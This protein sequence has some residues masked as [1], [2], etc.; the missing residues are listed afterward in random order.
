MLGPFLE[1]ALYLA[2]VAEE[3]SFLRA[4]SRLHISPS[5]ITRKI[6]QAERIVG[7]RLFERSTRRVTLTAAGQDLL[8]EVEQSLRHAERAIHLARYRARIERGPFRCGYC[9]LVHGKIVPRLHQLDMEFEGTDGAASMGNPVGM[10]LETAATPQ[11]VE[12]VLRGEL[13][14]GIGVAPLDEHGLWVEPLGREAFCV[15]MPKNHELARPSAVQVRDFNQ[16]LMFW[17]PREM[18]PA[19]YDATVE[20]TKS[21]GAEINFHPVYCASQAINIVAHGFGLALLPASAARCT[22]LGAVFRPLAD[23]FLEVESV[24]FARRERWR[25][26][27]KEQIAVLLDRL[28]VNV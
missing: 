4:A 7:V 13:D 22:H 2:A 9:P 28:R 6:N 15:G 19:M 8:P 1:V 16:E 10:V 20:Y 24:L 14:V 11:L 27:F 23:R 3:G 18:H 12:R 21:V 17:I 25:G 5:S 26:G